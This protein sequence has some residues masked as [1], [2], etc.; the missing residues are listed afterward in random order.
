M[1]YIS[2]IYKMTVL[3]GHITVY[4]QVYKY[5][6]VDKILSDNRSKLD[7]NI[8]LSIRGGFRGENMSFLFKNTSFYIPIFR[9]CSFL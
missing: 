5:F 4:I 9:L 1:E 8:E 6:T 2:L 7:L 3:L